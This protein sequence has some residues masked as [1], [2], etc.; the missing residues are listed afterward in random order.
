MIQDP[1]RKTVAS[2]LHVRI[3]I[4]LGGVAV[5]PD[6]EPGPSCQPTYNDQAKEAVAAVNAVIET[7]RQRVLMP[8][9]ASA[10]VGTSTA[11]APAIILAGR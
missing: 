3:L 6:H 8:R 10:A 9:G 5:E 2:V 4:A 7:I 1:F 11:P